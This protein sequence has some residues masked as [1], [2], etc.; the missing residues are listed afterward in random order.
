MST[1]LR[2]PQQPAIEEAGETLEELGAV[3][4]TAPKKIQREMLKVIFEAVYVD[5]LRE[6]LICVKP[7]PQFAPLFRMDGMEEKEDGCFYYK[8]EGEEARPTD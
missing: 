5:V 6:L 2:M 7:H 8:E 3:W 4:A 1:F